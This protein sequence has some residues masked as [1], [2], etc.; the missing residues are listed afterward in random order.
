[1]GKRALAKMM[2]QQL[3]SSWCRFVAQVRRAILV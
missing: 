1:M 2:Q 3:A